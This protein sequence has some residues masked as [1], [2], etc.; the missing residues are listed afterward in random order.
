MNR[1]INSV[2]FFSLIISAILFSA[3]SSNGT[4]RLYE[5][6]DKNEYE[7]VTF[8]LPSAVDL[9]E[10]DGKKIKSNLFVS[11]GHSQL[12]VLP[13][14]HFLKAAYSE[15][16]GSERM[17][18]LV[19]SDD[20]YFA[21]DAKAGDQFTFMHNGPE[22][23]TNANRSN[24]IDDVTIWIVDQRT[25]LKIDPSGNQS[26]GGF[27]NDLLRSSEQ[28]EKTD[29]TATQPIVE[30]QLKYWWKLADEKQREAFLLWL[31]SQH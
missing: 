16:W 26:Y 1:I 15:Y 10:V 28:V 14:K 9:L 29:H 5:G 27:V 13:G 6:A 23:L 22:D 4:I 30:T 19:A 2:K 25:G 8:N 17:G 7:I 21:V 12:Q 3:C 31:N 11:K 18:L 24:S 20:F